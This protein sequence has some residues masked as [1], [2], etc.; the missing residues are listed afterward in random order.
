[1]V[2]SL[3]HLFFLLKTNKIEMEEILNNIDK[4]YYSYTKPKKNP[5]GSNK[6]KN[7]KVIG[8]EINPSIGRLKQIQTKIKNNILKEIRMPDFI[9][10]GVKGRDNIS[11]ANYHKGNKYFFTTDL[12]N[13]FP[14]IKYKDVYAMFIK[15][16]FSQDVSSKLTKLTTFNY[17]VPQGIPTSTFIAN[18]VTLSADN[19]FLKLCKI[20][21][22]K[23]TRFVD[24]LSF[25]SKR[26]FK[27][28]VPEIMKIISESEFRVNHKKT[29]YKI[30]PKD[31]TGII[32]KNNSVKPINE[33][34]VKLK[35][36]TNEKTK[37]SL[38]NYINRVMNSSL[39]HK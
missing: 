10:G 38:T 32:V 2:K 1:M 20:H 39:K 13:F 6:T 12:I 15:F 31:I 3:K 7:G 21:E 37:I 25:S 19:S 17:S 35:L 26:D 33:I 11:N 18:L 16:G 28:L 29:H 22:L 34:F 30:G 27:E 14:S 8:R 9:Q 23:Y 36:T 4:Y 24:D 5:D